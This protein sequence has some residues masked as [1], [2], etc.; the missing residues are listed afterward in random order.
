MSVLGQILVLL[1]AD[2]RAERR[3]AEVT[4]IIVPFGAVALLVIPMALGADTVLLS[5][6]APGLYWVVLLLFGLSVTQRQTATTAPAHG[7]SLRLLGVDPA[8][9]FGAAAMA[10]TALLLVFAVIMGSVAVFLY[11]PQLAHVAWLVLLLPLAAAGLGM[12]GALTASLAAGLGSR[13]SLAPLLAVP[14]SIPV[15]LAGAQTMEGMR[16]G[17]GILR[18]MLLLGLVDV[19][20]AIVGVLS[21]RPLED[22]AA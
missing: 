7:E 13:T 10:N 20:V 8:A 22:A 6:L 2:L 9:R 14:L 21:A 15:L 5:R 17:T 18:W 16:Q 4:M 1:K 19:L 3:A 11:D 12:I